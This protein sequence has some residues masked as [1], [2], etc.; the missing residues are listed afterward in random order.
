MSHSNAV[1]LC[2]L[3]ENSSLI[4]IVSKNEM[5]FVYSY[6]GISYW[7]SATSTSYMVFKWSNGIELVT[8]SSL[9]CSGNAIEIFSI[10][11]FLILC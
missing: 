4:T 10:L 9:W 5:N 8:S 2:N 6:M 3:Y 7:T 1:S 11:Y